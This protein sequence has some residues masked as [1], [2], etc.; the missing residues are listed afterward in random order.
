MT[1]ILVSNGFVA[2]PLAEEPVLVE[3]AKGIEGH[4]PMIPNAAL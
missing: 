2:I 1:T 3:E 4:L